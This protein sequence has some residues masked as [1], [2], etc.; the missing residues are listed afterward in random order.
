M[1]TCTHCTHLI[2]GTRDQALDVP[3]LVEYLW[4]GRAKAGGRLDGWEGYL[5][6]TRGTGS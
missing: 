4:E 1:K 6:N 5:S 2:N 3:L